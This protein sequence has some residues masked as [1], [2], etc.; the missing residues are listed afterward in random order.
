MPPALQA[1]P[2][3]EP[4]PAPAV[5]DE[6]VWLPKNMRRA[7]SRPAEVTSESDDRRREPEPEAPLHEQ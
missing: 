2:E 1:E 4:E 7:S 3:P 6:P 5:A